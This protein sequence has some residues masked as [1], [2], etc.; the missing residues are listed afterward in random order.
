MPNPTGRKAASVRFLAASGEGMYSTIARMIP[1]EF[2]SFHHIGYV[3]GGIEIPPDEA[4]R[5]WAGA[6]EN[7]QLAAQGDRVTLSVEVDVTEKEAAFFKKNFPLAL[8]K[9]KMLAEG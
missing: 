7:Y 8:E 5:E 2:I 1:N 9:V 6:Q 4:A 3:K